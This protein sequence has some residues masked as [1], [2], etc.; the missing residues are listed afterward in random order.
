[1][2]CERGEFAVSDDQYGLFIQAD[3]CNQP[4]IKDIEKIILE[5]GLFE[6]E[7]VDFSEYT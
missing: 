1:M 5:T 3:G 2:S 7:N 4:I 6:K